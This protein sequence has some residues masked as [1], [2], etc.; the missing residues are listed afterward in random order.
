MATPESAKSKPLSLSPKSGGKTISHYLPFLDWLVHYR[1]QDSVG[2]LLAGV[3][4][5][6][7]LVRI[8]PALQLGHSSTSISKTRLISSDQL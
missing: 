1:R 7:M 4:V 6:I 3:M 8:G 5:A 2:D